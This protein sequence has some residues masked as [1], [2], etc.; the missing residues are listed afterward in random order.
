MLTLVD[1]VPLA[2]QV[3]WRSPSEPAR[4]TSVMDA[5]EN[6]RALVGR[7]SR[8]VVVRFE[9]GVTREQRQR[10]AAAGLRLGAYL[11]ERSFFAQLAPACDVAGVL[12]TVALAECSEIDPAWKLHPA[13]HG[14]AAPQY[15]LAGTDS[16]GRA[17]VG[18]YVVYHPDTPR[19]ERLEALWRHG[20]RAISTL[21]TVPVIVAQVPASGVTG[22]AAEDAVQ[23]IEPPLP[24]LQDVNDSNRALTQA[25]S[26]QALPYDLDGTGVRV[27][28]YDG[29]A[30]LE[31]HS[32]FGGRLTVRDGVPTVF[33][34]THVSGT[35]GGNGAGSA[36]LYRGMAPGVTI[37]SYGVEFSGGNIPL[38]ENPGDFEADYADA[39]NDHDVDIANNSI[40][41][42]TATNGFPC[43]ITGDYGVMSAV[44]DS[45]VRGGLG[46]RMRIVWANGNER[47][48]PNCGDL[49]NTTAPPAT[50]KNHIAVGAINANDETMTSFSSW[51]PVDD[52]RLRPDVAA[53]GCEAGGDGGVTSTSSD[54]NY[55]VACGTSMAAPTVTGLCALLL[56][57]YRMLRPS[58]PDPD[59]AALKAVL[60]HTAVDL[61]LPGPD[62]QF[63]YGSVR[64]V[65]SIDF[66]GTGNL[67]ESQLEHGEAHSF[68]VV[69]PPG[70]PELRITLAWDDAPGTP[71][72]VPALVNDLDLVVMGPAGVGQAFPWH[73]DPAN[74]TVAATQGEADHTNNLE[75]VLVVAPT[76]GV[77]QVA[78]AGT[79]VPEGP[80]R[81]AIAVTPS[82]TG[83]AIDIAEPLPTR[84]APGVGLDFE[85]LVRTV[86]ESLVPGTAQLQYRL[87]SGPV[88][89]SP[90]LPLGGARYLASL[91]AAV[92]GA[93][94]VFSIRAEGSLSGLVT[95]PASAPVLE[96]QLV[97]EEETELF[98]DDFESDLGWTAGVAGDT[99]TAGQWVRVDPNGTGPQ[100]EDDHSEA[101]TQCFVTGQ[102]TPGGGQGQADVDGGTTTLLSPVFDL[103]GNDDALISYWRWFSNSGGAQ[104][105]TEAF[106]VEIS[107]NGG[108]DWTPVET[109]GPTGPG[110]AG[111]WVQHEFRLG[112]IIAATDQVRLRFVTQDP[113]PGSLVE[114]ALDD[115]SIRIVGCV[116]DCNGNA[117][118][119]ASDIAVGTSADLNGNGLPDECECSTP[120]FVRGD[121]NYDFTLD[122]SDA[123]AMLGYL[124]GSGPLLAPLEASDANADGSVNLA[125]PLAVLGYLL[126]GGSAPSA[127]FPDAGCGD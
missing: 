32:D 120:L 13:F 50:A 20:G 1:V 14:G 41:T 103:A 56:Q 54:G 80:Q 84:L 35:I 5:A 102:G 98:V 83:V 79:D 7:G 68:T 105:N 33:H 43:D 19:A 125:D 25:N 12:S 113:D 34:A 22:L 57:E 60:A 87:G 114:A 30:A 38:H 104:P 26:A 116:N 55:G 127:P 36:G 58:E 28:V 124:F 99:A 48:V 11:G 31:S 101:G 74:P 111:G 123:I 122:L 46:R 121:A 107:A 49:Y 69:V 10:L 40:G 44:I 65:D 117:V 97:V 85:V 62:Y 118:D 17:I 106:T 15:A 61:G 6:L 77:W 16:E 63:G 52:G 23:W 4:D 115:F 42:N 24:P 51:G 96:F 70:A 93:D 2:A 82:A 8:R 119:D 47:Q 9:R 66:L 76:A 37:E 90:L 88:Q 72:V 59:N 39:M 89:T 67:W 73:L 94:P 86:G 112:D 92:C 64:V 95:L 27:M 53:P 100:P 18:C 109:V 45:V 3:A 21:V 81:F 71:N 29:G 126:Q 91:P 110:T 78:I 75:Q 108:L